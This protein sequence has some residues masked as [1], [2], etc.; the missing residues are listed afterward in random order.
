MV[1]KLIVVTWLSSMMLQ[2][3]P[4]ER[5]VSYIPE[6]KEEVSVAQKRYQIIAEQF[7][8]VAMKDSSPRLFGGKQGRLRTAVMMAGIALY[9]SGFRRDVHLGQGKFSRGDGGRSWCLLQMNIGASTVPTADPILSTWKGP[10][11]VGEANTW[12]CATAGLHMM[13]RSMRACSHLPLKDRLSVYTSGKCRQD[14][15]K[16][17]NRYSFGVSQF[18]RHKPTFTDEEVMELWSQRQMLRTEG[19]EQ[20]LRS[21]PSLMRRIIC[22]LRIFSARS[23]SYLFT[24]RQRE[25]GCLFGHLDFHPLR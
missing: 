9:E 4:P 22:R 7:L 14:E 12:R 23:H 25:H 11:L 8:D 20:I 13:A 5:R 18:E 6:A 1:T 3:A 19:R 15:Y 16:A 2:W 24:P 17:V 21:L 10:D